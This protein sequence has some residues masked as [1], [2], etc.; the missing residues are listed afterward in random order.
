MQAFCAFSDL[1]VLWCQ[2]V[3]DMALVF[4]QRRVS[5]LLVGGVIDRDKR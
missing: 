2:T 1:P 4:T 3:G 5:F